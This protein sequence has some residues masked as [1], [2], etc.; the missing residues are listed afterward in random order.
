MR[1]KREFRID[2]HVHS[3]FS[4]E[5]LARPE[6][7]VEAA[8]SKGLDGICITEHGSLYASAPFE[9]V[10]R[11]TGFP[12]FRGVELATDA[13]HMLVYGVRDSDWDDWGK[14]IVCNAQEVILRARALGGVAVPAHPCRLAERRGYVGE[15]KIVLDERIASLRYL[16]AIEVCNGKHS[17]NPSI[18]EVLGRFAK[19]LGLGQTGGSDAHIPEDVGRSYTVF[20]TPILTEEDLVKALLSLSYY[21][22]NEGLPHFSTSDSRPA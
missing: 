15:P 20:R 9:E 3:V 13:G 2:L 5:S 4:G 12:I 22:Q 16:A 11:K 18:C 8:M 14:D 21:P 17:G 10:K 1:K 7:I 19:S 6:D